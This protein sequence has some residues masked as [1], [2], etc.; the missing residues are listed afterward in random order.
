MGRFHRSRQVRRHATIGALC[1]AG[2]AAG[3]LAGCGSS[4][5]GS[6]SKSGGTADKVVSGGIDAVCKAGAREG[7]VIV[8]NDQVPDLQHKLFAAF[9]KEH[10]G[11]KPKFLAR[12]APDAVQEILT[13]AAAR[14]D[15]QVDVSY[16]QFQE[17][18]PL[19]EAGLVNTQIPFAQL[20][21][22]SGRVV[23]GAVRFERIPLGIVYNTKQVKES[24]LPDT[25]EEL[26]NPKWAGK[27]VADPGNPLQFLALDWGEQKT[28]DWAKK[29]M[30][31]AKPVVVDG[32]TAGILTVASGENALTLNGRQ[33]AFRQIRS[34]GAPLAMHFMNLIPTA[35]A[36][37]VVVKGAP[38]PNA[39]ACF[40]AWTGSLSGSK[41][42]LSLTYASNTDEPGG[43][44]AGS[45]VLVLTPEKKQVETILD[46]GNQLADIIGQ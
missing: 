7:S 22:P 8:W 4:A 42:E 31:V 23:N 17:A 44:P 32:G 21:V 11:I 26:V 27:L 10:P 35:D 29:L 5:G 38:H 3:V 33:E 46:T 2:L 34:Q 41:A 18:L 19:Y 24:D 13:T 6:A 14:K 30:D 1:A 39:A 20:G 36:Y 16:V 40:A 12:A 25:Y 15:Q 28:L 9:E 37:N 43:A 45:K